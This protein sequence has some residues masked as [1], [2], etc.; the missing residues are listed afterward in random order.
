MAHRSN[1]ANQIAM[2]FLPMDLR[3]ASSVSC[4]S[5]IGYC[6][7]VAEHCRWARAHRWSRTGR[8]SWRSCCVVHRRSV[9]RRGRCCSDGPDSGRPAGSE[10]CAC[11]PPYT[12]SNRIRPVFV[13]GKEE[14]RIRR[15]ERAIL[16][17]FFFEDSQDSNEEDFLR[18]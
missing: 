7:S 5:S 9:Q 8:Y 1:P 3:L 10:C 15:L 11:T 13:R 6:C 12:N 14:E 17:K 4:C 2:L 16:I 18:K